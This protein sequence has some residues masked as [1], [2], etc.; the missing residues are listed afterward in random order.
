MNTHFVIKIIFPLLFLSFSLMGQD[1]PPADTIQVNPPQDLWSISNQNNWSGLEVMTWNVKEFPLSSNTVNYVSEIISDILPD[2]IAFQEISDISDYQN[3][4]SMNPA[5]DFIH[6]NYGSEVNP[7]LG[8]AVRNDC[9]E[10]V[11]YTTLFSSEG[12]AFAYRYPLKAELQWGCGDAAITIQLINIHMKAFDE[13][14]NQRL[15]ASQILAD[16][17]QTHISENI[18]VAGDFND[19]IDDPEN[20]NSLWPLVEDQNSYFTTT[21]I[22]GNNYYNS[23]PWGM[24][25]SFIDHILI[26]TELFDEN[27]QSGE[28]QTLR[29]D[30][31]TSSSA[32]Q[33]HISDHR[34]VIWKIDINVVEFST[35]LVIN[36]I[37]N[38]PVNVTDSYGEWFEV[39]NTGTNIIDLNG[40]TLRDDGGDQHT[41][42]QAG[43]LLL[44]PGGFLV[45][46]LNDNPVENGGVYVDYVYSNFTL[47]NGWDEV[48]FEHP[49]GEILDEVWYDNGASFPDPAGASMMLDDPG[50]DNNNGVH[51]S[52]STQPFGDGDLGTPGLPNT[53]SGVLLEIDNIAGWNMIGLPVDVVDDNYLDLFP[54]AI[55]GTLY[56]YNGSYFGAESLT[57]GIGYWLRFNTDGS[58]L[59]EGSEIFSLTIVL[60]EGW[61]LITG[62][63]SSIPVAL[64][65][66]PAGIIVPGT[67]YEFDGSYESATN[68]V[69]GKGYWIRTY[70]GGDIILSSE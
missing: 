60:D 5:Y 19:E 9:V 47:G 36:E 55:T 28:I 32:Y 54:E 70:S 22:A 65:Q 27:T 33:N 61:N 40:L 39:T 56:A 15:V 64:I 2:I 6:T 3:F 50:S 31:Y 66:D 18:I 63:T 57:P 58:S 62:I 25:A 14:F 34:P 44:E 35:G 45:L 4:A 51:W 53:F 13:G 21:P 43:G 10:I 37:M 38:N 17:I 52:I 48:I 16:Y 49:T 42:S 30:D 20:D 24:Y 29:I 68:L 59:V 41:I 12:W 26:T 11:N 69:P 23:F 7:D 67:I 46:G 8:M 1:C